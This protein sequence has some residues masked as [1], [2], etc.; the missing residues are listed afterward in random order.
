MFVI[1][2]ININ[3]IVKAVLQIMSVCSINLDIFFF[4]KICEGRKHSARDTL[5]KSHSENMWE[6]EKGKNPCRTM[7]SVKFQRVVIF[8]RT[9]VPGPRSSDLGPSPQLR[10]PVLFTFLRPPA[11]ITFSRSPCIKLIF[12]GPELSKS[13][14]HAPVGNCRKNFLY[15]CIVT[16]SNFSI[17]AR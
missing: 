12:H 17:E 4:L 8:L 9:T 11:Q 3:E 16:I 14:Y 10:V 6:G 1:R 2:K 5:M 7:I 15:F 13:L